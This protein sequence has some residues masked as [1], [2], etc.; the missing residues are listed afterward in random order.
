MKYST[1]APWMGQQTRK[2]DELINT[3]LKKLVVMNCAPV[4]SPRAGE[5]CYEDILTALYEYNHKVRYFLIKGV[6][7]GWRGSHAPSPTHKKSNL[8]ILAL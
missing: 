3:E 6:A 5:V 4:Q 7:T 1:I 2:N 8:P